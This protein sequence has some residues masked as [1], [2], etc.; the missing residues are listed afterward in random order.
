M[1][2]VSQER[3][4]EQQLR[5]IFGFLLFPFYHASR[6]S[7]DAAPPV[8]C[9]QHAEETDSRALHAVAARG[10]DKPAAGRRQH[11]V[12]PPGLGS[13]EA[14]R[15]QSTLRRRL[16]RRRPRNG[17]TTARRAFT[18]RPSDNHWRACR[19]DTC[20]CCRFRR[21][22]RLPL[23]PHSCRRTAAVHL[24]KRPRAQL[25]RRR[26]SAPGAASW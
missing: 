11:Q 5:E 26:S 1:R 8:R 12:Q 9:A 2:C 6:W 7:S 4:Q 23:T 16:S 18:R 21:P 3:G 24:R 20:R 15:P 22:H 25:A 13:G 10:V 17:Q 14:S 19:C